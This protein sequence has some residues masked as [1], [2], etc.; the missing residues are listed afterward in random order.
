M[1]EEGRITEVWSN[2][3]N[4]SYGSGYMLGRGLILTARHV[5]MPDGADPPT[6][7][8][9]R[10]LSVPHEMNGLQPADL[11]WPDLEQLSNLEG[12]DCALVQ[13]REVPNADDVGPRVGLS[14]DIDFGSLLPVY[15]TGFPAF[16]Q[17]ELLGRDT[18]QILGV[19]PLGNRKKAGKYEISNLTVR[20][21][22]E[23]NEELDWRGMS[24]SALLWNGSVVGVLI[25]RKAHGERYDFSAVRIEKLLEDP[26]FVSALKGHIDDR[27]DYIAPSSPS[28]PW[29][30]PDVSGLPEIDPMGQAVRGFV[31]RQDLL[32]DFRA[33][34]SGIDAVR[35]PGDR[36]V[37][38]S[39]V[40]MIW[41]DG[42][43]GMGKSSFLRR[44]SSETAQSPQLNMGFVDFDRMKPDWHQP[45]SARL[46]DPRDLFNS[47][48]YRLAKI[49]GIEA[50]QKY[51]N[52]RSKV[53]ESW[54][55][56]IQL[57]RQ[58]DDTLQH[59]A[60][61]KSRN[62]GDDGQ[63]IQIP[64]QL[65]NRD[66]SLE[67]RAAW[68]AQFFAARGLSSTDANEIN[69]HLSDIKKNRRHF[70]QPIDDV[71]SDFAGSF[72]TGAELEVVRR[73]CQALADT[74]QNVLR[75]LCA[76]TP[77][78]LVL[79][80][81]E[82]IPRGIEPWLRYLLTPLL[83]GHTPILILIGSQHRPSAWFD[84]I[85]RVRFRN[86]HF[87]MSTEG[88]FSLDDIANAIRLAGIDLANAPDL[89][90][91]LLRITAG[92]P[93]ALAPMIDLYT[94]DP[95]MVVDELD[96]GQ[97]DDPDETR[98]RATAMRVIAERLIK[99]LKD[100]PEEL[101]A[102]R[103]IIA[104]AIVLH[105]D[106][107][108]L[109]K[110]WAP[111]DP[112][113]RLRELEERY[114]L[115][116]GGNLHPE[117]RQALRSHWR[118]DPP[119]QLPALTEE[120]TKIVDAALVDEW[121]I[122]DRRVYWQTEKLNLR[123]WQVGEDGFPEVAHCLVS[124][125]V[126]DERT[127]E[128]IA[129][130]L[131]LRPVKRRWRQAKEILERS[132]WPGHYWPQDLLGWVTTLTHGWSETDLAQLTLLTALNR[133]DQEK[134]EEAASLFTKAF[135]HFAKN[136]P[137]PLGEIAVDAYTRA[138]VAIGQQRVDEAALAVKLIEANRVRDDDG[139]DRDWYW[140]LH[141]AGLYKDAEKYCR[142]CIE[143]DPN[144]NLAT[145]YL[146]HLL[147]VHLTK[148][149]EAISLLVGV[150]AKDKEDANLPFFLADL[151]K[152]QGNYDDAASAYNRALKLAYVR[153]DKAVVKASL[154]DLYFSK[155]SKAAEAHVLRNQALSDAED[156]D[157][158]QQ[159]VALLFLLEN[160]LDN[161]YKHAKKAHELNNELG[162]VFTLAK[163]LVRSQKWD[164]AEPYVSEWIEKVSGAWVR[165]H[166]SGALDVLRGITKLGHASEIGSL[167]TKRDDDAVLRPLALAMIG[168]NS[169]NF[170][171][172]ST[173]YDLSVLAGQLRLQL[174]NVDVDTDKAEWPDL[175]EK[176]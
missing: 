123:L 113:R 2:S 70:D 18:E 132:R 78:V 61:H 6:E 158:V 50:L 55:H 45:G 104:L 68:L 143:D 66:N 5:V 4:G 37:P 47:I 124:S 31:G 144:N 96:Q 27:R 72:A 71:F 59:F 9:A 7:I 15:A 130:A 146:A 161:A 32:R 173:P 120:L 103:D 131:E 129:L 90:Q 102:F 88:R 101:Q 163:V 150:E 165:E 51:W 40:R 53:D 83:D 11:V 48:A 20:D 44:A 91:K 1:L 153:R 13:L 77:L 166:W 84:Y 107:E 82:D 155:M 67:D 148:P 35:T 25:A 111:V 142:H 160:D 26:R 128:I 98:A 24:G 110:L 69:R 30:A 34:I 75:V 135:G 117:I 22:Q 133:V 149:E 176:A 145:V 172:D 119:A 141:D 86:V 65:A 52:I 99:R 175:A 121:E 17:A 115:L 63:R 46:A 164:E 136:P 127:I 29:V 89:P 97:A 109:S 87:S 125:I 12:P 138:A 147:G 137:L 156:D 80:T 36:E 43:G 74:L 100:Q 152:R 116:A 92:V 126:A 3:A 76:K 118:E 122:P 108:I 167:L 64:P 174:T 41:L 49:Y 94:A 168:A 170:N 106:L 38:G 162:N 28:R 159:K 151:Y 62:A 54:A 8:R 134:Y 157:N 60:A 139:W 79:D 39:E 105:I 114:T 112:R 33:A 140:L 73:P 42:P 58:L 10:P 169:G 14:P 19:V 21:R 154:A 81:C 85:D 56:H 95:E 171:R 23:L 57:H 16:A 93:V